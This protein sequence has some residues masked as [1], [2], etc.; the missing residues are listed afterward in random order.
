MKLKVLRVPNSASKDYDYLIEVLSKLL[1][2][3]KPLTIFDE[4]EE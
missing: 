2:L 3:D 4:A 1:N